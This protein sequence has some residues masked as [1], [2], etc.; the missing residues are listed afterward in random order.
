MWMR[1]TWITN[2]DAVILEN[3]KTSTQ[4]FC[5][6]W[7][8][9]EKGHPHETEQHHFP[10]KKTASNTLENEGFKDV[11]CRN[12]SHIYGIK[13]NKHTQH[14]TMMK[15][16]TFRKSLRHLLLNTTMLLLDGN[17]K[18]VSRGNLGLLPKLILAFGNYYRT[19]LRNWN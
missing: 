16:Q 10:L 1:W 5:V 14:E 7:Q 9:S 11:S 13:C 17:Q 3:V 6:I 19:H 2:S 12:K 4:R 15:R 18:I 8:R